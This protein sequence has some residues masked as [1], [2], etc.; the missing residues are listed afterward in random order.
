MKYFF[1]LYV[2]FANRANANRIKIQKKGS[3][4]ND[5]IFDKIKNTLV[6]M[7][8]FAQIKYFKKLQIRNS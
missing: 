4:R 3:I 8:I 2:F 1:L 6:N 5:N 7:F